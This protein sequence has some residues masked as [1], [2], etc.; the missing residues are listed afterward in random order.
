MM[1]SFHRD[2]RSDGVIVKQDGTFEVKINASNNTRLKPGIGLYKPQLA[3]S[4]ND[5]T[6]SDFFNDLGSILE[7]ETKEMSFDYFLMHIVCWKLL[8]NDL[9]VPSLRSLTEWVTCPR[10]IIFGFSLSKYSRLSRKRS[11]VSVRC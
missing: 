3:K 4:A 11:L 10:R 5:M 7:A 6:M 9:C 2:C 1:D 8:R